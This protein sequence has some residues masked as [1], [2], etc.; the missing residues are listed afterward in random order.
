[1]IH[2]SYSDPSRLKPLYYRFAYC[3]SDGRVLVSHN[4]EGHPAE[5][6]THGSLAQEA[7][8]PGVVHGYAYPIGGGWRIHDYEH[9]PLTD[10]YVKAQVSRALARQQGQ[11]VPEPAP[12]RL[13]PSV[14]EFHYGQP[15]QVS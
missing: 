2:T 9:K 12:M 14:D 15:R 3:P 5:V 6:R 13:E 11:D 10:P 1:M 8:E 7:N 4:H